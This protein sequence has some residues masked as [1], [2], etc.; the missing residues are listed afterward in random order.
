LANN[1]TVTG[2]FAQSS[3]TL[4]LGGHVLSVSGAASISGGSINANMASTG[5]YMAGDQV[6]LITGGTGSSFNLSNI[7]SGVSGLGLG[8]ST[9]GNNLVAT[10]GNAYIGG[11]LATL[12]IGGSLANGL[13]GP[14]ALHIAN[15][16]TL[17]AIA[18]SGTISG[19]IVNQSTRD[20][21]ISGGTQDAP[22]TITGNGS[23]SAQMFNSTS[24]E[25]LRSSARDGGQQQ[26][27]RIC[28]VDHQS[29]LGCIV[30]GRGAGVEQQHQ[31]RQPC[32]REQWCDAVHQRQYQHHRQFQPVI[33]PTRL[34]RIFA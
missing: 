2:N 3:G 18:N 30:L 23:Q 29:V 17:G 13:G 11:A 26:Q 28:R 5:N 20:L 1:V 15:T 22:G 27:Q 10:A 9:N 7:S 16:G 6:T 32:G 8:G 19:N 24:S 4:D 12:T 25:R 34:W 14:T 33:G 21:V 31:C